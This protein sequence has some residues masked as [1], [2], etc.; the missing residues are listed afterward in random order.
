MAERRAPTFDIANRFGYTSEAAFSRAFKGKYEM[1][2][3]Q[4]RRFHAD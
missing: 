3:M 4:W 2:P 1:S